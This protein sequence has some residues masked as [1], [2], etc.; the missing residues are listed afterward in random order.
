M[1]VAI[2]F[3]MESG[4]GIATILLALSGTLFIL[5]VLAIVVLVNW[6]RVR[7]R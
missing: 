3:L 6:H 5:Y 4:G 2:E 7:G 1:S